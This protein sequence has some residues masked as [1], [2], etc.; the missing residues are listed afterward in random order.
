MRILD[1]NELYEI[2][3]RPLKATSVDR[4]LERRF[5]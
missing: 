1:I 3:L 2:A 5:K 4:Y